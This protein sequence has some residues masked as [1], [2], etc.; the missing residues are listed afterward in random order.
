[1]ISVTAGILVLFHRKVDGYRI[2]KDN[3]TSNKVDR[4]DLE[5]SISPQINVDLVEDN[6][7]SSKIV[8]KH[9]FERSDSPQLDRELDLFSGSETDQVHT[10]YHCTSVIS[11][12]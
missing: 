2:E 6:N 9:N 10:V 12:F 5:R 3:G 7:T 8:I 11:S 4:H 1:M